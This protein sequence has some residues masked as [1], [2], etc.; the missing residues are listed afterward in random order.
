[1]FVVLY[2]WFGTLY[3]VGNYLSNNTMSY[4]LTSISHHNGLEIRQNVSVDSALI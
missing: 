3:T 2:L 1:M 4:H